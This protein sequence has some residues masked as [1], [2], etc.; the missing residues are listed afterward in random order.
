MPQFLVYTK[1]I[2]FLFVKICMHLSNI[3]SCV[4]DLHI[5]DL[6]FLLVRLHSLPTIE[7]IARTNHMAQP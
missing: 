7:S 3:V 4:I 6:D 5:E 2:S 1:S